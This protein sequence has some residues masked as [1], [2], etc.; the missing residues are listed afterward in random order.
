[1]EPPRGSALKRPYTLLVS[2]GVRK[3]IRKAEVKSSNSHMRTI[4]VWNGVI[5]D[6]GGSS[7]KL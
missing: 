6:G 4:I 7:Q 1:M 2:K 3:A 5:T